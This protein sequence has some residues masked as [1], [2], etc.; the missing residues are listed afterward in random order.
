MLF[1]LSLSQRFS[2]HRQHRSWQSL[3]SGPPA[4]TW[5]PGSV[6]KS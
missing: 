5:R 2:A 4:K 1:A 6:W 3:G